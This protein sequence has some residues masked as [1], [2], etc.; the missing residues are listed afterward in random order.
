MLESQLDVTMLSPPVSFKL[1]S[2]YLNI[3]VIQA[4]AESQGSSGRCSEETVGAV[5]RGSEGPEREDTEQTRCF[6]K[7]EH[8]DL[9]KGPRPA[10]CVSCH[11]GSWSLCVSPITLEEALAQPSEGVPSALR[12]GHIQGTFDVRAWACKGCVAGWAVQ[13]SPDS[14]LCPLFT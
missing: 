4:I 12:H 6:L 14:G 1:S 8:H 13:A 5:E 9:A 11:P 10:D 7:T 3:Y 2:C